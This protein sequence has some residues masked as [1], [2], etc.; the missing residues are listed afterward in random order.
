MSGTQLYFIAMVAPEPV[1][2]SVGGFKQ[3]MLE[4]Y[5]CK[6]ALK[7]PAHITL[8]PPFK[9]DEREEET[10]TATMDK[11]VAPH[12]AFPIELNGFDAF[13]PR[14]I[15][16]NILSNPLLSKLFDSLQHQ[17]HHF[18]PLLFEPD[19]RP[20]HPHMTIANRDIP[21][22]RFNEA[23]A[24]F[25]SMGYQSNWQAETVSLL[26]Y[27]PGKWRVIHESPLAG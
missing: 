27:S 17:L 23:L 5:G 12:Q 3:Y 16:V 7:S 26:K 6:V 9:M 15:F 18:R 13:P 21:H 24:Y 8:V 25:H 4:T 11:I 10:L 22:R 20:F 14:V 19:K 1:E 2:T